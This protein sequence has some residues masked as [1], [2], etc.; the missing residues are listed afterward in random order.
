MPSNHRITNINDVKC[1]RRQRI[2]VQTNKKKQKEQ[3]TTK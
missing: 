1:G 3:K 2:Y